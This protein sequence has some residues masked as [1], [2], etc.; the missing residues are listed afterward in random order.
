V[1]DHLYIQ[2]GSIATK[3][4]L[5]LAEK[6]GGLVLHARGTKLALPLP[7]AGTLH[8][9]VGLHDPS[10]SAASSRCGAAA[11]TLQSTRK[12]ALRFR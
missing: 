5:G 6:K 1:R 8:V 4:T 11:A 7:P 2:E 10:A 3:R 9:T 12:G